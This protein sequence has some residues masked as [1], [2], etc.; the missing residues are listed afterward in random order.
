MTAP[1]SRRLRRFT[2]LPLVSPRLWVRRFIFLA[3]AGLVAVMAVCFARAADESSAFFLRLVAGRP[4]LPFLLCPAGL[5][6]SFLLTRH[7]FP[8]AQGSGIPQV[9]AVLEVEDPALVNRVLSPRL[10]IGKVL[11]TLLGLGSGASIGRE[12]PTVQVAAT[13]MHQLGRLMRVP[14]QDVARALILAGGG[15]GIAAAFNTPLA[16]VM[17]AIEELSQSFGKRMAGYVFTAVVLAGAASIS[18]VGNYTYFG[19]TAATLRGGP[20]LAAILLSSVIGGIGGGVFSQ[21]LVTFG[22]GLPGAI[23]RAIRS[24]PVGFAVGCGLAIAVIGYVSDGQTFGT[25]YDQA[26]SLVEGNATMPASYAP[27][28]LLATVVSYISGIPGG[29]FAPS[30]SVGASLGSIL[31]PLVPDAPASAMILLGMTAYFAAVVQTPIT[32]TI[33]VMEMTSDSNMTIPLMATAFLS[34][35]VSRLVCRRAIYG[36]MASQ[37][38]LAQSRGR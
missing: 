24:Y 2:R 22:R 35:G 18:M 9:I 36:A 1:T 30:L 16:G 19:H 23:G 11:L 34:V 37:F 38:L 21:A 33:I 10:A 27:L 28:K 4:W 25:G 20:W 17:F 3:G 5:A 31:A 15:A 7:V 14:S 32:A 13:I 6:A 26:R 29:I 12:G 8:G